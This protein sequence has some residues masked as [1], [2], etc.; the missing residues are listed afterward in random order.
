MGNQVLPA[1]IDAANAY[2][3]LFVPA[4]SGQWAP[5]VAD[6]AR[7]G[8]GDRVLDVACGTARFPSIRAMV[9]ADLR[10]WLP[11]TGVALAEEQIQLVLDAADRTLGSYVGADGRMTFEVSAH[12]V[13][14][15]KP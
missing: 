14:A 12:I 9:E 8:P 5:Q 7:I 13:A 15:Q 11:V 4:L 10:G 3:A 2:E 6:A 1:Q